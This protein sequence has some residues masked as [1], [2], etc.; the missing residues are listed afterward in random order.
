MRE[1]WSVEVTN[2]FLEAVPRGGVGLEERALARD[3]LDVGGSVLGVVF[4]EDY[5]R[6][7]D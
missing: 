2:C 5:E 6:R 3:S 7:K 4:P 1:L